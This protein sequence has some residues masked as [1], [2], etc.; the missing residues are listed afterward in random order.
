MRIYD[1]RDAKVNLSRLI[2]EAIDAREPFVIAEAGK[3]IV[4]VASIDMPEPAPQSRTGIM[5]G[6][7]HVP[8]DFD[9]MGRD[10]IR[11]LFEGN[12]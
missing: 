4:R 9:S 11:T 2:D 6:Q 8:A 7:I 5:K 1:M 10:V 3:P 12:R